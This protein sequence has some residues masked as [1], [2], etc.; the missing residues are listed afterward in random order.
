MAARPCA[1]GRRGSED[2]ARAECQAM[3]RSERLHV[4][5]IATLNCRIVH[6]APTSNVCDVA[7]GDRANDC[8]NSQVTA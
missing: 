5:A 2:I 1:P 7:D 6:Y 8:D 3:S 4:A